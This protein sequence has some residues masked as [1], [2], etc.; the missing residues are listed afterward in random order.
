MRRTTL[1][2]VLLLLLIALPAAAV[3]PDRDEPVRT[4][5]M[6]RH[7]EYEHEKDCDE[8]EGC[9]L[10][11]LGR[12]QARLTAD[13]LKALPIDFTSIQASAMTR[14]RQT[15]G[16][17]AERFPDLE[18]A[19]HRDIR[20]CTPNTRREDIMAYME[21]GEGAACEANLEAAWRRI[22]VPA[23]ER[24]EYDIVV[25]HGN[26]IR[27]FVTRVL[28]VDP[29][30]WLGMSIANCS[31]TVVQVRADGSTKLIAFA[32]SGHIPYSM[33]TYPG[34]EAPQ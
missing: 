22:F 14:A 33:T 30:A 20:E 16:I 1:T 19:V 2:I 9:G 4:I 23:T 29:L 31:L 26:V 34:T 10:V 11:A 12:Q 17:I 3:L 8:D 7:G 24:N 5:I 18:L 21:P 15:G 27:W 25:C 32:D 13:R 28:E 6:I